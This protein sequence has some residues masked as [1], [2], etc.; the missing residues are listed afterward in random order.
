MRLRFLPIHTPQTTLNKLD[1]PP[2]VLFKAFYVRI[3]SN[4]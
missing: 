2:N 3:N 1:Y 4:G